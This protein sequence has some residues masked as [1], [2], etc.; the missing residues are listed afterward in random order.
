MLI[1][2]FEKQSSSPLMVLWNDAMSSI[3]QFFTSLSFL[4]GWIWTNEKFS[5]EKGVYYTCSAYLV[6]E[7]R[8]SMRSLAFF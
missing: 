1:N 5:V 4:S 6:C 7:E 8:G 2:L 3:L